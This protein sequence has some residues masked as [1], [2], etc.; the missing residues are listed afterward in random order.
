MRPSKGNPGFRK[1]RRS[2]P[3]IKKLLDLSLRLEGL[4][5][6]SSTHAAG[7]VISDLPL[8]DRIPLCKSPKEDVVTQFAMNDI[9]E[10][11]LTKFDFLGLKTLTVIKDA[12]RFIHEGGELPWISI[13]FPG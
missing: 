13:T 5:R 9:S 7:V 2:N 4:N 11:G 10:V 12:L 6:H 3:R 1:R 8:V